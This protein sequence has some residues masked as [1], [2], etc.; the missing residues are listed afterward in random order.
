MSLFF[1]FVN[2]TS[3]QFSVSLMESNLQFSVSTLVMLNCKAEELR[4][5]K[6]QVYYIKRFSSEFSFLY[7][8]LHFPYSSYYKSIYRSSKELN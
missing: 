4:E 6:R 8:I 2:S 3:G 7:T 1:F 5:F